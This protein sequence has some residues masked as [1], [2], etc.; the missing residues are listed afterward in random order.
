MAPRTTDRSYIS[1]VNN[2]Q[3][4]LMEDMIMGA[5]MKYEREGRLVLHKESEPFR[6]VKNMNRARGRA[7]VQFTAKAQP[8]FVG[9]LRGGRLIAIEAK[10]TQSDMIKQDAV[11]D[12]QATMLGKYSR[13][14]AAA[15]VCC[16]IGTGFDLKYFMVP[17]MVWSLMKE[18]FGHKYATAKE[19]DS[20]EVQADMVIHF[21]DY[22]CLGGK[23]SPIEDP[24]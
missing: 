24:L 21:L 14:G 2:T 11:T 12:K 15:F 6:V 22:K 4:R 3:G 10:Y 19:L 5:A 13:A 7:E 8:D 23:S 1:R 18:I 16:G 9:C 17:W 20:Y